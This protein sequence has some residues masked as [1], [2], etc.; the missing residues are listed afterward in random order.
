VLARHG[1]L[2][3]TAGKMRKGENLDL[4]VTIQPSHRAGFIRC[5]QGLG[6]QQLKDRQLL[7][8]YPFLA[9]RSAQSISCK[10]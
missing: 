4:H 6:Q 9:A 2:S 1:G 8:Y 10:F 7:E 5:M 3:R